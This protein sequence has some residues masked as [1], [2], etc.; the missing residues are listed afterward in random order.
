MSQFGVM[1]VAGVNLQ[2]RIPEASKLV[3]NQIPVQS[4]VVKRRQVKYNANN[5]TTF[6]P[7]QVPNF[8][9]QS[10]SDFLIPSTAI[11]HYK[12]RNTTTTA[13]D[14]SSTTA[15]F[16]DLGSCVINRATARVSGVMVEDILDVNKA[17]NV[18]AY[19]HMN[20]KHY[21][22]EG[23]LNLG[24]WKWVNGWGTDDLPFVDF[25]GTYDETLEDLLAQTVNVMRKDAI[26]VAERQTLRA[27]YESNSGGAN[28]NDIE[29]NLPLSYLFGL[30]RS[31]KLFPLSFLSELKLEFLLE[32]AV[33]AIYSTASDDVPNYQVL[34]MYIV[35]DVCEVSSDYVR[36]LQQSFNSG[37]E[38]GY[39]LPVNTLTTSP[40]TTVG[41]GQVDLT[42]SKSTPFMKS[43]NFRLSLIAD[44]TSVNAYSIS[45]QAYRLDANPN[46]R[47]RIGSMP[48]PEYDSLRSAYEIYR[49]NQIALSHSGNVAD[50]LGIS[51][52]NTWDKDDDD[53]STFSILFS[54]EKISGLGSDY[55][56]MDSLDASLA[57][58]V[59]TLQGNYDANTA[60]LAIFEHTRI[61]KFGDRR[62]DVRA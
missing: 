16:D 53:D 34:D 38:M 22:N 21:S 50:N 44:D 3:A 28:K 14:L 60:C 61:V 40:Q 25:S 10:N 62:V 36:I 24:A 15:C 55:Y 41:G 52:V 35:A 29:V 58:G 18:L 59:I 46:L 8:S 1:N 5:G 47:L 54:F 27:A 13:T 19:Q 39:T 42:Y 2:E 48:Y 32:S 17:V 45:G 43:V 12:L 31:N 20:D 9:I 49:N 4:V 23:S 7:N 6:S 37:E 26:G 33:K 56:A 51:N 57:G 30:F 11:L